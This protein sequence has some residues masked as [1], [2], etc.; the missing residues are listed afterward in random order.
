MPQLFCIILAGGSGNGLWPVSRETFPK[1]L[2]KLD[3]EYTLFQRTFL[4]A[5]NV[6]NDKN[7][8][9]AVNV[10]YASNIKE[11]LKDIR[12][13]FFRTSEYKVVTEP[14]SKNTAPAVTLCSK[15]IYDNFRYFSKESPVIL[16]VPS[17]EIFENIENLSDTLEKAFELAKNGYIVAFGTETETFEEN[18]PCFKARKH[19]SVTKIEASALKVSQFITNPASLK[20]EELQKGGKMYVNTG[21]YMF[22][23]DT[24]M[25]ELKKSE[26]S[27]YSLFANKEIKEAFP[28]VSLNDYEDLPDVSLE[29]A[30]IAK[31]KKLALIPLTTKWKDIG[32]WDAVYDVCEK[33]EQ[34]NCF[35]GKVVD[36]DSENSLVYSTDKLVAT[37]GLKDMI[38]VS[39]QDASFICDRKHPQDVQKIYAKLNEKNS[40]TKE[41]H[42]TVFRPW[43]YYTVLENG[44]GFLTKCI[45][46][47]PQAKLSLQKHFH[48]SE[49]WVVLEGEAVIIKG[50]EQITLQSGESIDIGIEEIHSL[51]NH[52]NEQLKII[53]V[54]LGDI[55]DENDIERI[56]D[57][58]G[59]V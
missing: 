42:K 17:D 18:M 7:I 33:N 11:Q 47:N 48:R 41:I 14:V 13:K 40:A 22:G 45:T 5:A 26:K 36:T 24:Y 37:L 53:E 34:G 20:T 55:L 44:E 30:V 25:Q 6:V 31:T 58:Y 57:I 29:N 38:V 1:Q 32:S 49:H 52:G 35:S 54:Q 16:V 59:R 46:V 8:I 28:T 39:T 21:I 9:T 19:V 15:Y 3:D 50:D 27:I 4:N 10:K 56:E 2:L 43:G 23:F 51:Q 12:E